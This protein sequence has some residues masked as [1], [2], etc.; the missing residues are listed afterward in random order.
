ALGSEGGIARHGRDRRLV[1][2]EDIGARD[3]AQGHLDGVA[4]GHELG[5]AIELVAGNRLVS[6][7]ADIG[8]PWL[9][10]WLLFG[11][12][13][14]AFAAEDEVEAL[15]AIENRDAALA[16]IGDRAA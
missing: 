3:R 1:G 16:R 11:H 12:L 13:H 2:N 4:G 9:T 15:L 8:H 6:H 7:A 10:A 14:L 5:F